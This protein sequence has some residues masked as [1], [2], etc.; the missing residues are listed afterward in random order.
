MCSSDLSTTYQLS[1]REKRQKSTA[2]RNT[3]QRDDL[4]LWNPRAHAHSFRSFKLAPKLL[5]PYIVHMQLGNNIT[6]RHVQMNT[7]HI[8]HASRVNPYIGNIEGAKN[9]AL[10][11]KNE[12][13]IDS[14][15]SHREI[16]SNLP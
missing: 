4:I 5:G 15:T 11:D 10:M 7:D 16:W 8:F 3:F 2:V 6:C 1:R 13:M 9:I 14:I 12:H